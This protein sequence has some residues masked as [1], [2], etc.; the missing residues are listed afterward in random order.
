MKKEG[1]KKNQHG[2]LEDVF[3]KKKKKRMKKARVWKKQLKTCVLQFS[4]QLLV[5][6]FILLQKEWKEKDDRVE[7]ASDTHFQKPSTH[8]HAKVARWKEK[9]PSEMIQHFAQHFCIV[10]ISHTQRFSLLLLLL[11]SPEKKNAIHQIQFK[12]AERSFSKWSAIYQSH[13]GTSHK[14]GS[15]RQWKE[16]KSTAS[17]RKW[18]VFIFPFLCV[19]PKVRDNHA[20]FHRLASY[21]RLS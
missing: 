8:I 4:F 5:F 15:H 3:A 20:Q 2:D 17:W 21:S 19:S 18:K 12:A 1:E 13:N 11:Y 14:T 16:E 9:L 10:K 7:S 6:I